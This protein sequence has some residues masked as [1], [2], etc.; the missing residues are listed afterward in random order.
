LQAIYDAAVSAGDDIKV[1]PGFA[2]LLDRIEGNGV[3]VVTIE[4]AS[5][6]VRKLLTQGLGII[7]L[8]ERGVRGHRYRR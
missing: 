3:R 2:A 5:R 4:D 8:A 7:A 1:R 6:F